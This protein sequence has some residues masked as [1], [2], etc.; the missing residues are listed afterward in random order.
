MTAFVPIVDEARK[1]DIRLPL[2]RLFLLVAPLLYAAYALLTPPFQTPDEHQHLFRAWQLSEFH[3]VGERRGDTSGGMLPASLGRAA[4]PEVGSLQPHLPDRAI[5]RRPLAQIF[6]PGAPLDTHSPEQF[7][8]FRGA[9]V[10][11]PAGYVPQ[12]VSIWFGE[13]ADLS[14]E[15]ILRLGRLLNAAL[16]II[17]IYWALRLT[18]VGGP[19]ILFVGLLPMTAAASASFGQD[20]IVIGGAC[21]LTALGLR[22]LLASHRQN[23]ELLISGLV[24]TVLTLSKVLYLPL[25]MI[26]GLP[27]VGQ[28][29]RPRRFWPWAAM[30]VVAALPAILWFHASAG[31]VVRP[32][33]DIPSPATRLTNWLHHP[34]EF[35]GFLAR[36]YI[37]HAQDLM[38]TLFAFGWMN[39]PGSY[40]AVSLTIVACGL[41]LIAG[42]L[43]ASRLTVQARLWCI[44]CAAA[45][46]WSISFVAWLYWTPASMDWINGLQ[47]RYF[48]P[49]M[50]P[51][52]VALLRGRDTMTDVG[53]FV[54]ILLIGANFS[55]L[56]TIRQAF[57]F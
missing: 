51:V 21:L 35:P 1:V 32:W 54:P 36:T 12:V 55:V 25:A 14:I 57:Y 49:I 19:A 6:K 2:Q 24:A 20:G 17:L 28:Q 48:I 43:S 22:A 40:V 27:F 29:L 31:S 56:A 10:Y 7:Y 9:V 8:D 37:A 16:A 50:P 15:N 33:S 53:R 47:G 13:I 42:D 46:I 26:G 34:L 23:R 45:V 39:I 11:S 3:L 18:P 41:L 30:C 5:V 4:L 44:G 52:L 38:G